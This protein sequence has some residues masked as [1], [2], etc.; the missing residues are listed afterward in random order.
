LSLKRFHDTFL[1]HGAIPV[2]LIAR[3]MAAEDTSC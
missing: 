3:L 1:S 2:P